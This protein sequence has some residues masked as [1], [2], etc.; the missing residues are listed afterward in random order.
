MK[1]AVTSRFTVERDPS[2][3]TQCQTCVRECPFGANYYDAL[4]GVV[5]S[6][7]SSCTGCRNCMVY[8]PARALNIVERAVSTKRKVGSPRE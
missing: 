4:D 1:T 6:R 7:R 8:C 3:C 2:R 5:K